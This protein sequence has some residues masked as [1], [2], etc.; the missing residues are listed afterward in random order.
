MRH[1]SI[2]LLIVLS[3]TCLQGCKKDE[4]LSPKTMN[5]TWELRTVSGGF[6]G[7]TH[8]YPPGNGYIYKFTDTTFE[9]Y[10]SGS[11][12]NYG[13]Y[14]IIKDT[15]TCMI[16]QNWIILHGQTGIITQRINFVEDDISFTD[17]GAD[18]FYN[19]YVRL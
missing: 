13:T 16:F 2:I 14:E 17:C 8:N 6:A 7:V 19:H 10:N 18:I 11:I 12:T 1:L 3:V 15:I 9:K 5:G 4:P